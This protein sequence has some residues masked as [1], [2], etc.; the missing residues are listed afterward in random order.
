MEE[1]SYRGRYVGIAATGSSWRDFAD[2]TYR[3]AYFADAV[4]AKRGKPLIVSTRSPL[5]KEAELLPEFDARSRRIQCIRCRVE[6][7]FGTWKPSYELQRMR[8]RG[9]AEA[10]WQIRF[11]TI[12]C[13]L[14][15]GLKL[16][17]QLSEAGSIG[18][19]STFAP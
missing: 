16:A 14:K 1:G 5:H 11:N 12:G 15:R 18:R 17:A 6:K 3:G 2:S 7:T 8:W 19:E 9:I 4:R 13:N 10:G